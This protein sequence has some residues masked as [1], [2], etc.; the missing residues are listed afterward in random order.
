[1]PS[2]AKVWSWLLELTDVAAWITG[3]VVIL[4]LAAIVHWVWRRLHRRIWLRLQK[5]NNIW[6]DALWESLSRPTA[7]AIWLV[8]IL[9]AFEYIFSERSTVMLKAVATA[10]VLGIIVLLCWFLLRLVGSVERALLAKAR[11]NVE[12]R[13]PDVSTVEAIGKL[14]RI[15][16]FIVM[17]LIG[18]QT[19]GF[20]IAGVLA[21][22]GIGGLAVSFAAKDMLANFFGGLML[23]LDRPFA[24]GDYIRS[25]DR[26]VEGTVESIGWRQTRVLTMQKR[27]LYIPNAI[28]T[29]IA[30]E[31]IT[32]MANRR[33]QETIGL[34]YQDADKLP[35][36][37][38]DIRTML[39]EH[40]EIRDDVGFGVWFNQYGDS[41][42]NILI[43]AHTESTDYANFNRI[44]EDVLFAVHRIVMR[45]GADFAFPTRSVYVESIPVGAA[46][47]SLKN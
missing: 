1:M 27:P 4:S 17:A 31:N 23:Y 24:V 30:V 2:F 45:H 29:T 35:L 34:R 21:F 44:K 16:I 47:V 14:A 28:F 11:A 41:S 25:P 20:S 6:D 22:G 19:L 15:C 46:P 32:R 3:V 5:T 43:D 7:V 36:V 13:K 8:A 10:R 9:F 18:L 12:E 40:H 38:A 26:E 42:L 37:I 39:L 33:I